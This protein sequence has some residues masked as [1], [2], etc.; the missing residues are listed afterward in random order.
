M[1]QIYIAET[2]YSIF[3]LGTLLRNVFF[4]RMMNQ[5]LEVFYLGLAAADVPRA[6]WTSNNSSDSRNNS[7]VSNRRDASPGTESI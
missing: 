6:P 2:V 5:I 4:T 1:T 7:D 3:N